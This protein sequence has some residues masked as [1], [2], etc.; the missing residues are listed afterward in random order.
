VTSVEDVAAEPRARVA[1]VT[2][3]TSG[4]G[5]EVARRLAAL[6]WTT[7]VV[8]RGADRTGQAAEEIA[9]ETGNPKVDA[10]AIQDLAL[11][12]DVRAL[13]SALLSRYPEI[14]LLI[15]NAGGY[16]ARRDVT[17]DGLERTFAL[18][19]LTP[20]TLTAL[21]ADRL[22]VSAP[23]RVVNVASAAHRGMALDLNDLQGES[24]FQG[25]SAYGRSKLALILLSREFARRLAG[26]GV[27][28]VAVHPG[29]I[30]SGFGNNNRGGAGLGVRIAKFLFARTVGAGARSVVYVATD[31]AVTSI[32][33]EYFSGRRVG[34]ASSASFD[35][36]TARALYETCRG[37]AG[38][39]DLPDPGPASPSGAPPALARGV[40][41]AP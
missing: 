23:S 40:P 2:G 38:T 4:I 41:S 37:L 35:M 8:G 9:R 6:G 22:R 39:P 32:T 27:S 16:F 13:A 5:R 29:F 18:N 14:H 34:H 12:S 21:L 17:P 36:A 25:Y 30:R 31:P 33:G 28:V 7:V 19:V 3:A 24:H 11:R 1:V 20:Y 10:V 15:N 26:T